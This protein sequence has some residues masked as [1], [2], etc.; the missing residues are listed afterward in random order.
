LLKDFGGHAC[1]R[2]NTNTARNP[3]KHFSCDIF[4]T[5]AKNA[6]KAKGEAINNSLRKSL[7][8]SGAKCGKFALNRAAFLNLSLTIRAK[9]L[10]EARSS[11]ANNCA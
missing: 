4:A 9:E 10:R 8:H 2:A 5:D 3:G 1:G 11:A 7:R 6:A